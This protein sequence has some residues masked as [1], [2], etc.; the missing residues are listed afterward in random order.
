M[1]GWHI[2]NLVVFSDPKLLCSVTACTIFAR[3]SEC[4]QRRYYIV[5]CFN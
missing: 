4:F 5:N 3:S 1:T 2:M